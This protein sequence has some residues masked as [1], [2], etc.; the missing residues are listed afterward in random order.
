MKDV[1]TEKEIDDF[2]QVFNDIHQAILEIEKIDPKLAKYARE[3]LV[4]DANTK[5]F[6]WKE[7]E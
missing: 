5:T 4:C 7:E 3:H 1:K 6:M 2:M